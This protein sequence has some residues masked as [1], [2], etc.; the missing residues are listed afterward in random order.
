MLEIDEVRY[1][2]D[3][4]FSS[5]IKSV[6]IDYEKTIKIIQMLLESIPDNTKGTLTIELEDKNLNIEV[7][8]IEEFTNLLMDHPE[9]QRPNSFR[10]FVH[11]TTKITEDNFK[12]YT[13]RKNYACS[14]SVSKN[15]AHLYISSNDQT[16][17]LE[18]KKQFLSFL[19]KIPGSNPLTPFIIVPA[20][21]LLS[22][23]VFSSLILI[24]SFV[25]FLLALAFGL[26][27]VA[28][29]INVFY[30]RNIIN[31]SDVKKILQNKQT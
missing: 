3:K 7:R 25:A 22:G 30:R 9:Y 15:T 17:I 27:G 8:S 20:I 2:A 4:R 18:R 28:L 16:W 11:A 10:V 12:D 24:N 29:Y 13:F 23:L 1:D 5:M 19:K 31:F 14:L 26:G 21:P 6:R